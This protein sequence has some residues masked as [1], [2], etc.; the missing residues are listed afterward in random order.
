MS[1]KDELEK[2][3]KMDEKLWTLIIF[4]KYVTFRLK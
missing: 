1:K 4:A 3:E 2:R